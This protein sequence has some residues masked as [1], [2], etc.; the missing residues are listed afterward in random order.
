MGEAGRAQRV[1]PLPAVVIARS[2]AEGQA[3][4][5]AGVEEASLL[6]V[7]GDPDR[8]AWVARSLDAALAAARARLKGFVTSIRVVTEQHF[9]V[10]LDQAL[11]EAGLEAVDRNDI[12]NAARAEVYA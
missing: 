4:L 10:Q 1:L 2:P 9:S 12:L 6:V 3:L 5:A 7:G 8:F 11:Q